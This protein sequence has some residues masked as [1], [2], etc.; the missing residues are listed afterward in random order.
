MSEHTE[1]YSA[2]LQDIADCA[3]ACEILAEVKALL[4]KGN[5]NLGPYINGL[6]AGFE[7]W[8]ADPF[9]PRRTEPPRLIVKA[10]RSFEVE[11]PEVR[12]SPHG[13][14]WMAEIWLKNTRTWI[15]ER[16]QQKRQETKARKLLTML[17]AAKGS[18]SK[19]LYRVAQAYHNYVTGKKCPD[20][21]R[22][23]EEMML[24]T[25]DFLAELGNFSVEI[26][27]IKRQA[28]MRPAVGG[29]ELPEAA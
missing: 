17:R 27:R 8:L 23:P 29:Q 25:A 26:G 10:D 12:I 9:T 5:P 20:L 28:T 2:Q 18:L 14:I 21:P 3:R 7:N 6:I 22:S 24:N 4:P 11:R 13:F 16:Q 1:G 19:D 15:E